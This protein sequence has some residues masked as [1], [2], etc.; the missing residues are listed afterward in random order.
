MTNVAY[1]LAGSKNLNAP[2]NTPNTGKIK[3]L[4]LYTQT[5]THL[6]LLRHRNLRGSSSPQCATWLMGV[7]VSLSH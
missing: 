7:G 5:V 6:I 4:I 1:N 2:S 3:K